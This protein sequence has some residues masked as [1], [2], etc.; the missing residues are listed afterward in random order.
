MDISLS[1]PNLAYFFLY[2]YWHS[3]IDKDVKTCVN[4]V[5]WDT[6]KLVP[7]FFFLD[8]FPFQHYDK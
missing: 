3:F 7:D 6:K 8:P 5:D 2:D 1:R 4:I